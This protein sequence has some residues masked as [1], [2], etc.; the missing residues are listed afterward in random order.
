MESFCSSLQRDDQFRELARPALVLVQPE[1]ARQLL[2]Q[3]GGALVLAAFL[4]ID[5]GGLDDADRIEA[6]VLEEALVFGRSDGLHQDWRNVVELHHPPLLAVA[7]GEV[8]DQLRLELILAARRVVLQ[9]DDLRDLA[10]CE[11]DQPGFLVEIRVASGEDLD[12]VRADLVVADRVARGIRCSRCAAD[13]AAISL[14]VIAS[15]TASDSGAA[16][17]FAVLANGP[18]RSFSSITRAYLA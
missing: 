8:G 14:G 9:G 12:G 7:A 1:H 18:A 4:H 15:P 13:R 17:I 2:A 5:V 10:A 6:G 16:K 11:S 3:R